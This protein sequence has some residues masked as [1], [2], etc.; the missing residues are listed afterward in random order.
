MIHTPHDLEKAIA[1][2]NGAVELSRHMRSFDSRKV[3]KQVKD[4]TEALKSFGMS[5]PDCSVQHIIQQVL[6]GA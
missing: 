5:H 3:E 2:Y 1:R 4:A 6:G